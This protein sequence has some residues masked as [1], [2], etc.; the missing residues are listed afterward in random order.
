MWGRRLAEP[1]T[2]YR[3]SAFTLIELLVVIAI[4]GIL[5]SML[6]PTLGRAKERAQMTTCLNNLRQ[7]SIA[8]KLYM[9]D[10]R[11]QFPAKRVARV[12]PV[13][14]EAIGGSW[15]AQYTMGGPDAKPEWMDEDKEAPPARYRP[16]YRYLLPSEVFRC[17]KD[18]GQPAAHL[19]GSDWLNLGCSYHYNAGELYFENLVMG[20]DL[21]GGH[22][23]PPEADAFADWFFELSDKPE[24]WVA[25]PSKHILFHEP[26]ARTYQC[27]SLFDPWAPLWHC[28]QWHYATPITEFRDPALARSRFVSPIAFVDGHVASHDFTRR[29]VEQLG[30]PYRPTEQ[31]MWYKPKE[32]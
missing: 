20:S 19:K 25:E 15:N 12:N 6:L 18:K 32:K 14:G 5:A 29:L 7:L 28:Y 27:V 26:P 3:A 30:F 23:V 1:E 31:W 17:P 22:P 21:P 8:T 24:G 16:L 9:D 11:S 13:T 2:H 4:I 10:H